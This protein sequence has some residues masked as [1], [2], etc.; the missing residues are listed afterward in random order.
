MTAPTIGSSSTITRAGCR[1]E[2]RTALPGHHD[3]GE[4]HVERRIRLEQP[5]RL[6]GA[7]RHLHTVAEPLE[8]APDHHPQPIFVFDH[9][10]PLHPRR[11]RGRTD[12]GGG[13][14][15][16]FDRRKHHGE[17]RAHTD[18][19]VGGHGTLSKGGCR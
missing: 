16:P 10:N 12:R 4:P 15:F 2:F 13:R 6:F 7:R 9:E 1:R 19:A 17:R 8:Q 14:H 11:N 5:L 18:L 3:V